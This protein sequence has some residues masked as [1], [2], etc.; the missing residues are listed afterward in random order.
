MCSLI[1]YLDGT[2][3]VNFN[4]LTM[5]ALKFTLKIFDAS[6]GQAYTHIEVLGYGAISKASSKSGQQQFDNSSRV[7]A[8]YN[9]T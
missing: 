1:F 6:T 4:G 8:R 5:C 7:D 2:T 3:A 9:K